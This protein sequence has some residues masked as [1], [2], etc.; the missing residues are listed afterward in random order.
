MRTPK[1]VN[2]MA[3]DQQGYN[4]V[5]KGKANSTI[6]AL[7]KADIDP[8]D[9][10]AL[11]NLG[12]IGLQDIEG[13]GPKTA[14]KIMDMVSPLLPEGPGVNA[15]EA[16][17]D[18]NA[19]IGS[20][21]E[22]G[23]VAEA[24][25]IIE[26]AAVQTEGQQDGMSLFEGSEVE[27]TVNE[28]SAD[29]SEESGQ[30]ETA[31]VEITTTGTALVVGPESAIK[32]AE[33]EVVAISTTGAGIESG[34]TIEE[35][36]D[37]MVKV[38][39]PQC[40][41]PVEFPKA[42][43]LAGQRPEC[44]N[45]DCASN[46]GKK[47]QRP[48]A[49]SVS[50]KTKVIKP[51]V[52]KLEEENRVEAGIGEHRTFERRGLSKAIAEY[53]ESK[54]LNPDSR[55]HTGNSAIP[56]IWN[57]NDIPDSIRSLLGNKF[58]PTLEELLTSKLY[59]DVYP[60]MPKHLRAD[61]VKAGVEVF[62]FD[63]P[64]EQITDPQLLQL[65]IRTGHIRC[66]EHSEA[67]NKEVKIQ[68]ADGTERTM[69]HKWARFHELTGKIP[70]LGDEAITQRRIEKESREAKN[71]ANTTRDPLDG[72]IGSS[73]ASSEA[74]ACGGKV[75]IIVQNCY[76]GEKCQVEGC[77]EPSVRSRKR[78]KRGSKL[79]ITHRDEREKAM[80]EQHAAYE[81]KKAA[82]AAP[83]PVS[84][85]IHEAKSESVIVEPQYVCGFNGCE[86]P[87]KFEGDVCEA[88]I[89]LIEA[90]QAE[91]AEKIVEAKPKSATGKELI[92]GRGFFQPASDRPNASIESVAA[93]S[94]EETVEQIVSENNAEAIVA[95]SVEPAINVSPDTVQLMISNAVKD[96]NRA[97]KQMVRD[98]AKSAAQEVAEKVARE[99]VSA[100]IS[101]IK[102]P[103][104][105]DL[106]LEAVAKTAAEAAV[107]AKIGDLDDRL[108]KIQADTIMLVK[109]TVAGEVAEI[110]EILTESQG[111]FIGEVQTVI[112]TSLAK[113]TQS[114]VTDDGD[115]ETKTEEDNFDSLPLFGPGSRIELS[116]QRLRGG[117]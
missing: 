15:S 39:C 16:N 92:P 59:F 97:Q 54:G 107:N 79:C 85:S 18:E 82:E 10:T 22:T 52:E 96:N 103:D 99:E 40:K 46:R 63:D 21:T 65:W 9:P 80:A 14:R 68:A 53:F 47:K 55:K 26:Q 41:E 62:C 84:A 115:I 11:K 89:S 8:M 43:F 33:P 29:G 6:E 24:E 56:A 19:V 71:V 44:S 1:E 32:T 109:A 42:F 88:C 73:T 34:T 105:N 49:K 76:E 51:Q 37:E 27:T 12:I 98:T 90:Q 38:A 2:S 64:N 75:D 4:K 102:L 94:A 58:S 23:V 77:D 104:S 74:C 25:Q 111:H 48:A 83:E 13:I 78:G 117:N 114:V 70:E 66:A 72:I 5:L 35:P 31:E 106:D 30:T 67:W 91:Q 101:K 36:I 110:S 50:I 116:L 108:E 100:A 17:A 112:E 93:E 81:A 113:A 60:T 28:G 20:N 45:P 57:V 86:N 95:K 7:K 61:W 3:L 69:S 87:V